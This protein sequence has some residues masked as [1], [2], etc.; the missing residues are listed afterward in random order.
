MIALPLAGRG[1]EVC[2]QRRRDIQGELISELPEDAG[3][4]SFTARVSLR[5]QST[6]PHL[7]ST[8]QSQGRTADINLD[9]AYWR[10]N[11]KNKMLQRIYGVS[12]PKKNITRRT[13]SKNLKKPKG[14]IIQQQDRPRAWHRRDFGRNRARL[15]LLMF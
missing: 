4:F 3:K 10:G 9:G 1:P 5:M 12:F 2:E 15:P 13:Y 7:L 11:E 6:G 14:E 8:E